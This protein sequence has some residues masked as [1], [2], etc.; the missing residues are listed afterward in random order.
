MKARNKLECLSLES[1]S[2]QERQELTWLKHLTG[3][4]LW[5]RLSA[6]PANCRLGWKGFAGTDTPAVYGV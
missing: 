4:P 6:L 2:S 3:S 5:G 1:L